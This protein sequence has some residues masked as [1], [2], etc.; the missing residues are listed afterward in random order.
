MSPFHCLITLPVVGKHWRGACEVAE[1]QLSQ[2]YRF[3]AHTQ[4][5]ATVSLLIISG[6][7]LFHLTPQI[8]WN[9]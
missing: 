5:A 9:R 3:E 8:C 6:Y 1:K 7:V 4:T 2:T